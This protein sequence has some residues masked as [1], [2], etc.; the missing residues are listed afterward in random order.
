MF[1]W[2]VEIAG[3]VLTFE[4]FG[5]IISDG[6]GAFKNRSWTIV[7]TV[8]GS[9]CFALLSCAVCMYAWRSYKAHR[10]GQ[11]MVSYQLCAVRVQEH[12]LCGVQVI[13][14]LCVAPEFDA[15]SEF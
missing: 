4:E 15:I 12:N 10:P 13:C 9:L 2:L 1:L 3:L 8:L 7:N 5:Q 14:M 6:N 11:E